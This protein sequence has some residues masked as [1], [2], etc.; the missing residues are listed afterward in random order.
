MRMF[1]GI[2]E[3]SNLR[4]PGVKP[5]WDET[6]LVSLLSFQTLAHP[7]QGRKGPGRML[8]G[9]QDADQTSSRICGHSGGNT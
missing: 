6:S 2:V 4:S 9:F 8:G 3:F 1:G 5:G 7:A